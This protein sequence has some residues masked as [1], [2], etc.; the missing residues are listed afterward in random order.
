MFKN[1]YVQP[2]LSI[3]LIE[4]SKGDAI[5]IERE[6]N[7]VFPEG[8]ILQKAL[9]LEE[10][11]NL[12]SNNTF[13]VALLDR[14]LPDANEFDGLYSLQNMAP[15]LPVIFLTSYQNEQTALESIV[16][17]AQD[18]L[19][20]DSSNGDVIKRAIEF[21]ILRKKFEE[22]LIKH[23]NFDLLTGLANRWFFENTLDVALAKMQ[24]NKSNIAILFIDLD[25]FK[26]INDE[27]GH[28]AGDK[29]LKE[30]GIRLKK[31]LRYYDTP[32]RF[33]GDEFAVLI[34]FADNIKNVESVAEKI[35]TQIEKP[36]K[37]FEK[38]F[39]IG[40]SIGI[41]ICSTEQKILAETLMQRA[42]TAMYKAK[43]KAGSCYYLWN[44][45]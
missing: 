33:G 34:E 40:V 25:H 26:K 24:R 35:I 17:G 23:A 14:T 6:L 15:D 37:V 2:P 8:Y 44:E 9:T 13:H 28:A 22:T 29:V 20:K 21:A 3:L 30:V 10:A 41:S 27:Y 19:L 36:I 4:D 31:S 11:L 1:P 16:K 18:Y 5:L 38:N 42:D 12:L 32:A 39:N 7:I 43:N 45:D